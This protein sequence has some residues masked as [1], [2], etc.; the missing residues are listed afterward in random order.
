MKGE[1]ASGC[2]RARV[3]IAG[4]RV[5]GRNTCV[6]CICIDARAVAT[7]G[8]ADRGGWQGMHACMQLFD[9]AGNS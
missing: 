3:E 8:R 2:A 5:D 9:C 7:A 6:G 4:S 1:L